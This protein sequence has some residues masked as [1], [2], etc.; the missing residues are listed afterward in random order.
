MAKLNL[1]PPQSIYYH[2]L[3][4]MFKNDPQV[5]VIYDEEKRN[6]KLYVA[7]AKKAAALD[8]ILYHV[9]EFGNI[10]ITIDVIPPNNVMN[11]ITTATVK[12]AFMGNEA[13][14]D[15]VEITGWFS[16]V[17]VIFEKE[18]VQYLSDTIASPWGATS[19]LYEDIAKE[20]FDTGTGIFFCTDVIDPNPTKE[21]SWIF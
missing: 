1:L 18:V 10:T 11:S 6:I 20:I 9:K 16:G 8:K 7:D 2:E 21:D 13:V 14:A 19:T 15:I 12:D 3:N 17:Y 5:N 4:A